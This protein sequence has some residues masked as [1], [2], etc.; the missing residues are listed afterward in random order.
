MTLDYPDFNPAHQLTFVK[1]YEQQILYIQEPAS[2][3]ITKKTMK[4]HECEMCET[5]RDKVNDKENKIGHR[6][7]NQL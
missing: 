5:S 3:V 6:S 2:R 7:L 1:D 4:D